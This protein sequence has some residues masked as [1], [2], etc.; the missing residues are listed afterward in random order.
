MIFNINPKIIKY[1]GVVLLALVG[2]GLQQAKAV[3]VDFESILNVSNLAGATGPFG[4]VD[5][6]VSGQT[7]TITFTA[8]TGYSFGDGSSAA[9][10][11]NS[12]SFTPG[13]ITES[14]DNSPVFALNQSADGFGKF[15]LVVDQ[16]D[17]SLHEPSITFTV[18]NNDAGVTWLADG[19]NVLA[20]NEKDFDA[21]A[22]IF[23]DALGKTGFA[24]EGP[25]TPPPPPVPDSGTTAMLLGAGLSALGLMRRL[26]KS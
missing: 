6:S 21:A 7:A 23:S 8:A 5:I 14:P 4:T 19:S 3:A 17:F 24:G 25:G 2:L 20:F 26:A 16:H 11:L 18:T 1:I 12:G 22:H 10:E 9:V 13:T 15:D